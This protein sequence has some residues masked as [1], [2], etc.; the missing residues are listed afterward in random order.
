MKSLR[1]T[2]CCDLSCARWRP[3]SGAPGPSGDAAEPYAEPTSG[4]GPG[5]RSLPVT[6]ACCRMPQDFQGRGQARLVARLRRTHTPAIRHRWCCEES[7][8]YPTAGGGP[9]AVGEVPGRAERFPPPGDL[10]QTTPG[11]C[12]CSPS[13]FW[14]PRGHTTQ[15]TPPQLFGG[16]GRWVASAFK[17][18]DCLC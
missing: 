17:V 5:L 13:S 18:P 7:A 6:E 12:R 14:G 1:R 4:N 15:L 9:E 8:G 11:L 2:S 16:G 10:P 3:V